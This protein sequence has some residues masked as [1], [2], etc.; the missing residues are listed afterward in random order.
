MREMVE[1]EQTHNYHLET[2]VQKMEEERA[3]LM[4]QVERAD[5]KA[6]RALEEQKKELKSEMRSY[7]DAASETGL[8]DCERLVEDTETL[9]Q[10]YESRIESMEDK[11]RQAQAE[12]CALQKDGEDKADH[13]ANK[14]SEIEMQNFSITAAEERIKELTDEIAAQITQREAAECALL[15]ERGAMRKEGETADAEIRELLE[16]AE[17]LDRENQSRNEELREKQRVHDTVVVENE[18]LGVEKES[19]SKELHGS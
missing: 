19:L 6:D 11:L 2:Q 18:N 12:T 7:V 9:T 1:E 3:Q 8:A 5:E 13:A 4:D 16:R 17:E 10:E 15:K 14:G